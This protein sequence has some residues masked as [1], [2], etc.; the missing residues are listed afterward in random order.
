MKASLRGQVSRALDEVREGALWL[1]R[2]VFQAEG[3]ARSKALRLQRAQSARGTARGLCGWRGE[4]GRRAEQM[5]G[6]W[7]GRVRATLR[8][9]KVQAVAGSCLQPP[10]LPVR[11]LPLPSRAPPDSPHPFYC[12]PRLPPFSLSSLPLLLENT[13]SSLTPQNP[14]TNKMNAAVTWL[15]W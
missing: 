6:Q 10:P 13:G 15:I 5:P 1:S 2:E 12:L 8:I 9:R 4:A 14:L 3:T 11:R 7:S